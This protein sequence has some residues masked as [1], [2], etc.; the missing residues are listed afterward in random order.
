MRKKLLL[1]CSILA[2]SAASAQAG[3]LYVSVFAGTNI[4]G[5]EHRSFLTSGTIGPYT[6]V[7]TTEVNSDLSNGFVLG[8]AVGAKLDNWLDGLR[9]EMELSYRHNKLKGDWQ[10]SL[11][12]NFPTSFYSSTDFEVAGSSSGDLSRFAVMANVWY[13]IDAGS[14]IVPY[15]GGG[16]G[17]N[18]VRL[19]LDGEVSDPGFLMTDV[20]GQDFSESGFAWQLGAGANYEVSPGVKVGVG[21]RYFHGADIDRAFG[22]KN[23]APAQTDGSNHAIQASV[24]VDLN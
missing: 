24:T 4:T 7:A 9:A 12:G 5:D 21:Y 19:E 15:V 1:S 20:V 6:I 2:V 22:A 11:D 13:D 17:W 14:R 3:D 18:R 23:S 16:V 8:G 10:F